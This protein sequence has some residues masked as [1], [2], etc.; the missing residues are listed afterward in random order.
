MT[1]SANFPTVRPS[2]L[3]DFSNQTVLDPRVTFARTTTALYY[4]NKS[5]A[6]AEQNLLLQS[7]TFTNAAWT[8][9]SIGTP[10]VGATDPAGGATAYT[11][12]ATLATANH[13]LQVTSSLPLTSNTSYTLSCYLQAGAGAGSFNFA[14]LAVNTAGANYINANFTLTGA[15]TAGTPVAAGTFTS[16]GATIT[17]IGATAWYRCSVTFSATSGSAFTPFILFSNSATPTVGSG[18]SISWTAAGTETLL[19]YGAQLEQRSSPTVYTATTATAVNTYTPTL[20]TAAI[21]SPRFDYNPTT[22][23][24]L[25]LLLEQAATNLALYSS[26]YTNAAW[27]KN[28]T[29]I[30]ATADISPDGSQN[31]SLMVLSTASVAHNIAQANTYAAGTYTVSIYLKY[32]GQQYVLLAS[33]AVTGAVAY[34]NFDLLN[35]TAGTAGGTGS[36]VPNI[37]NVGNG[38]Y[39]CSLTVTAVV[40]TGSFFIAAS[41]SITAT[42]P[43]SL[44]GN[45]FNGYLIWG[46]QVELAPSATSYIA[47]TAGTATVRTADSALMT[48]TNFTSWYNYSGGTVYVEAASGNPT[49]AATPSPVYISDGSVNNYVKIDYPSTGVRTIISINLVIVQNSTVALPATIAA[50]TFYKTAYYFSTAGTGVSS[51][52]QTATTAATAISAPAVNQISFN[53]SAINGRIKKFAYY[54]AVLTNTQIQSLSAN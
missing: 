8:A 29:T 25:G 24:S 51:A 20:Q 39:R 3:L 33:N 28:A 1:I 21:N 37:Q 9:A 13:G 31:A 43:T 45:G 44:A 42:Y 4:D 40:G 6:L 23:E 41:N 49:N 34:C 15:G 35:G 18:G 2:L 38:W 16:V 19:V 27:T 36:P 52:G 30:T 22:R 11:L 17:Q 26:D 47:N 32:Y 53:N 14:A 5:A 50:N 10:V 54:P 12:T 7:N 48:G 46:A